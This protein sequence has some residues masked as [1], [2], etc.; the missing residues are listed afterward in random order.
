MQKTIKHLS[1]L[2]LFILSAVLPLFLWDQL[3]GVD[4]LYMYSH[5]K[6]MLQNGLVR[7]TDIF[8]MHEGFSF[9]YQKW[10]ACLLTYAV[11]HNFG[12]HGLT[13]ATYV[14]VFMLLSAL[15]LFGVFHN[16]QHML[17]N[18][19]LIMTAAFLME[20][21]GTLRFRPHVFA[22]IILIYLMYLLESYTQNKIKSDWKF[23]LKCILASIVLMWFHSTMWIVYVVVFLPYICNFDFPQFKRFKCCGRSYR[24][25][26]L[27]IAM[28][29]MFAAGIFNPNGIR[30]YA[31]MYS[32]LAATGSSYSH[33]DE[34]QPIPFVVYEPVLLVG[35]LLL[36]LIFYNVY[37]CEEIYIP[38]IYFIAGS[39]IMPLIS[40]R[41]VFYS[42]IFMAAAGMMQAAKFKNKNMNLQLFILPL[43]TASL[44]FVIIFAGFVSLMQRTSVPKEALYCGTLEYEVNTAIDLL[45]TRDEGATVF[46]TTAHVGSYCIY[47][48]FRPYTDCRAEVYDININ[49]SKDVLSELHDFRDDVYHDVPLCDGGIL[50]VDADYH[51]DY[52]VLTKYSDADRNIKQALDL[53][54]ANL[55]YGNDDSPVWVYS[56]QDTEKF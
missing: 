15:F 43:S 20:A 17:F 4:N 9:S 19:V 45:S 35:I 54:G 28:V 40:W 29:L 50:L 52:Y 7:D 16:K 2:F 18:T 1:I 10:A 46:N 56:F 24:M 6:D 23:Y 12:W 5:A 8:S 21:N 34:L 51:P 22:G 55:L 53:A 36:L 27:W 37:K 48:G 39:L 32:C 33:V 38:S 13:I 25:T 44:V 11:V 31:Y 42:A 49:H 41:L 3:Q 47:K 26:P 30:Q 14:L